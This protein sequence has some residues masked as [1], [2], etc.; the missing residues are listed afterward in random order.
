VIVT[1][2]LLDTVPDSDLPDVGRLISRAANALILHSETVDPQRTALLR[3][4]LDQSDNALMVVHTKSERTAI[5][6]G[7][8]MMRPGDGL[9][10]LSD[11]PGLALRQL[12]RS[13]GPT[14][15]H[16]EWID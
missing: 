13:S 4:G 1:A 10:V 9:L 2:G 6:R 5:A 3:E 8:A 11:S 7:L 15:T 14:A 12:G 16:D